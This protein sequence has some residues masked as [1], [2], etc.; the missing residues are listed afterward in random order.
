MKNKLCENILEY[1]NNHSLGVGFNGE[2]QAQRYY[3]STADLLNNAN[4]IR[5]GSIG[6]GSCLLHA[7]FTSNKVYYELSRNG[8]IIFIQHVRKKLAKKVKELSP[9]Q[10]FKYFSPV[11]WYLSMDDTLQELTDEFEYDHTDLERLWQQ[12][13]VKIDRKKN[14][15]FTTMKKIIIDCVK[16]EFGDSEFIQDLTIKMDETLDNVREHYANLMKHVGNWLGAAEYLFISD[17]LDA[18]FYILRFEQ[19]GIVLGQE[20]GEGHSAFI[21]PKR[22]HNYIIAWNE[23]HYELVGVEQNNKHVLDFPYRSKIIKTLVHLASTAPREL[24]KEYPLLSLFY[25]DNPDENMPCQFLYPQKLLPLDESPQQGAITLTK[26]FVKKLKG[27]PNITQSL[28][29]II[30]KYNKISVT[31]FKSSSTTDF[32]KRETVKNISN[33]FS[34]S[35]SDVVFGK[36][37]VQVDHN[38]KQLAVAMLD[39]DRPSELNRKYDIELS[40]RKNCAYIFN[41]CVPKIYRKKGYCKLLMKEIHS[42]LKKSKSSRIRKSLRRKS[43]RRKSPSRKSSRIRKSQNRGNISPIRRLHKSP[44]R[45]KRLSPRR[46]RRSYLTRNKFKHNSHIVK[47]ISCFYLEVYADNIGAVKCYYKFKKVDE[48][49]KNGKKIFLLELK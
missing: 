49:E 38:G 31:S 5:Y 30:K 24:C 21:N 34:I 27:K 19:Y 10:L 28:H 9:N 8:K 15:R 26:Q 16:T 45:R 7:I 47:K 6:D 33:C 48:Y 41:L 12:A 2:I 22:K 20:S 36:Y 4:F 11:Q 42:L 39:I 29:T 18:N 3:C 35:K 17:Q 25:N 40:G 1:N 13:I 43:L 23:D 32:W 44:S 37:I 14:I 46:Q